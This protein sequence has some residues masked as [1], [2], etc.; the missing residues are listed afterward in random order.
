MPLDGAHR[1]TK[2]NVGY[3]ERQRFGPLGLESERSHPK[4]R[5][6]KW[7]PRARSSFFDDG[8]VLG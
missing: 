5:R 2:Q 6:K 7:S 8:S 1:E 3:L 4:R